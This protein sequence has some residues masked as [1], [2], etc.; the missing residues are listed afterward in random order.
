MSKVK[1]SLIAPTPKVW[2]KAAINHI[3]M[4]SKFMVTP[5]WFHDLF[6]NIND[7]LP[8]GITVPFHV[9]RV[10]KIRKRA[11]RKKEIL[12]FEAVYVVDHPEITSLK[13]SS[14]RKIVR[15]AYETSKKSK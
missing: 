13:E 1:P 5:Y 10:S 14:R 9:G 3:G 15:E 8:F 2:A 6:E 4:K 12:A 7:S 11:L